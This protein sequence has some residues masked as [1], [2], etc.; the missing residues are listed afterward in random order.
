MS[1]ENLKQIYLTE[2]E[3]SLIEIIRKVLWGSVEVI[4]K[5]GNIKVIKKIVQVFD[6]ERDRNNKGQGGV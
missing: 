6:F 2:E 1:K 4:I 3:A 5:R